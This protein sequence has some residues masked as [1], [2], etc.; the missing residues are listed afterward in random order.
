MTDYSHSR[1]QAFKQCPF[2]YKA[3]YIDGDYRT[4]KT[5]EGF[6][7]TAVHEALRQLY[8]EMSSGRT[9]SEE[10]LIEAFDSEWET[11]WS[12]DVV[13]TRTDRTAEDYRARGR[14]MLCTYYRSH[15]P[16]DQ[17]QVV[18][19]ETNDRL[20]LTNGNRY[21]VRID[22]LGRVGGTFYVCDYK[23]NER[24]LSRSDVNGDQQLGMYALW[25]YRTYPEAKNVVMRWHSLSDDNV[26]D[27]GTDLG[28]LEQLN[29]KV[30][31]SIS[32]IEGCQNYPTRLSGLC[33]YC[34]Y[35]DIC[36]EYFGRL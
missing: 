30:L 31:R 11:K 19:L 26:I 16:F 9:M 15:R 13:V 14:A 35:H 32:E 6:M 4:T 36:P 17:M 28:D 29:E 20:D 1:I 21:Y 8:H 12:D 18:G 22:R 5:V 33:A 34:M 2:K 3:M 23:T 25:V 27:V 7:G 10:E 24:G